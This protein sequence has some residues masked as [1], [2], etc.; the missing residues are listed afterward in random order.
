MGIPRPRPIRPSERQNK[1]TKKLEEIIR[2]KEIA[3]VKEEPIVA[4]L[5]DTEDKT[6]VLE[7]KVPPTI[8][9]LVDP[10]DEP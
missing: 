2:N 3:R 5:A 10:H 7:T 6:E 1:V 4:E 9:K 8:A